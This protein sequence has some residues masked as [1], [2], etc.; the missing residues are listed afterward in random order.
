MLYSIIRSIAIILFKVLFRLQAFGVGNIPLKG[1]F[2]L[3]SNHASYLDPPILGAACPRV[4]SYLGKEGLFKNA[5][6]GRFLSA[7][8]VIPI[9]THSGDIA[10]L[11]RAIE[12]L[13]EERPLAIFPEGGRFNDGR[14]HQ[15]LEGIGLIAAKT[16]APIVP[17]FIA[18]S[19]KAMP[20]DSK[21]IYPKKIRIYFGEPIWPKEIS[22]EL[23]GRSLYQV[24][25]AKT[26]KEIGH[27]KTVAA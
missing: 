4:L 15:P 3:A 10:A 2:I 19:S 21:F 14:L 26:M 17:A 27:L 25:A 9:K 7:L 8:N 1:G 20:V 13:K 5:L 23:H 24:I 22:S 18:G 6:F 12:G 16:F 11:R